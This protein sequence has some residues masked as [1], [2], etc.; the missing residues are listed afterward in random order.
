MPIHDSLVNALSNVVKSLFASIGE[1]G[2]LLKSLREVEV[3]ELRVPS[4][5]PPVVAAG[6]SS[7]ALRTHA[8]VLVYAV[9]S[10]AIRVSPGR[11]ESTERLVDADAGY[12]IPSQH[13]GDAT[14]DEV[15]M[16][17]IQFISKRLEVSA[18]TKVSEGADISLFDGSIFS[19]LW[20]SKFPEIPSSL[21][22][23]KNRPSRFR[24]I[25]REV[26]I[27]VRS[28]A[29]SGVIP[30]FIAKSVRRSYYVDRLSSPDLL[31][32]LGDRANDLVLIE[33]MRRIGWLPKKALVLEPVHISSFKDMP[34]PLNSLDLEDRSLL[35]PLIP[36][37][38]TYVIFNPSAH[39][40]Q[41]TIPGKWS[42]EELAEVLSR[43]YPYSHSGYPDPLRVA[44]NLSKISN[45]ELRYLLLKLGVSSI[46]TGRELLG[47]FV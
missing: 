43:L 35:E 27:G 34:R 3:F 23:F 1:V 16:R 12:F 37:T 40:F 14:A 29:T 38:V 20:Y 21:K 36:I 44:H 17:A 10:V 22:S 5:S 19:F 42:L 7:W 39:A 18:L 28:I 47:E 4:D 13:V 11:A 41:V 15:V 30:L 6:D 32:K 2:D 9:Q 46:P 45:R 33:L 25:W 31:Q 24:D 8:M 26:V